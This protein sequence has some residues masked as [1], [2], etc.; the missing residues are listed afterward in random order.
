M[1]STKQFG[2][3]V[4]VALV[5]ALTPAAMAQT[6]RTTD[7]TQQFIAGGINIEG[8][9]ALEVGGIVLLRGDTDSATKAAD[10]ARY[11]QSLGYMRV[12]N[13]IRVNLAP[14]DEKIERTAERQLATRTLDGCNFHVDSEQGILTVSGRVQHELQKDVAVSLLRNIDGVRAV[15]TSIQR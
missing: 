13:L 15:H 8:L 9:R 2:A 10:A 6:P 11:A 12:A 4:S 7:L 14:D 1:N 3:A 5:L